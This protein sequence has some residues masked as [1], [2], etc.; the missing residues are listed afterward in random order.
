MLLDYVLTEVSKN[1]SEAKKKK[2]IFKSIQ[3]D[4]NVFNSILLLALIKVQLLCSL[5][6]MERIVREAVKEYQAQKL[7]GKDYESLS[8]KEQKILDKENELQLKNQSDEFTD[9]FNKVR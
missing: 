2:D 7:E 4:S 1:S 5:Q 3:S 8:Q 6:H 9:T